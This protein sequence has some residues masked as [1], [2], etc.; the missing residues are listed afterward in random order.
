MDP[1]EVSDEL[2]DLT[3]IEEM[4]IAQVFPVMSIYRLRGGQH[5]YRGNVI[6]FPQDV[7]EFATKL[8]RHPL[9]LDVLVIRC[10]STSNSEAFR[11]FRVRH[12]KVARALIWLKENNRYYS[13]I[14]IDQEVL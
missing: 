11:D 2:Q 3:E 7:Q 1:E 14:T 13:D 5:G 9:S 6:N 8:P 10:Q 4:L 12:V